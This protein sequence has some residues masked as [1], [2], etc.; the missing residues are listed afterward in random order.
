MDVKGTYLNGILREWVFM[1]QPEGFGDGTDRVC[2][3][4]K[5]IYG[6]KQSDSGHE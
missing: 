6:L 3:L 2:Q 4:I 5:T 1:W